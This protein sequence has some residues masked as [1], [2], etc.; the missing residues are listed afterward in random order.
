MEL[1]ESLNLREARVLTLNSIQAKPNQFYYYY[2]RIKDSSLSYHD[3][4]NHLDAEGYYI[5][6]DPF[7]VPPH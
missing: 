5:Q 6:S 1:P 7:P 4:I 3:L 2:H